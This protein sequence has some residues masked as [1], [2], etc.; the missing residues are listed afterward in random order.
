MEATGVYAAWTRAHFRVGD[1][2]RIAGTWYPVRRVNAK[3]LTVPPIIFGGQPRTNPDGSD[4]WTDRAPFDKVFGR[5]R[6]GSV[7]HT[8]PPAAG[9]LCTERIVIPTFNPEY[10]PQADGGPCPEPAIARVSIHHDGQAC[11]C[12]ERC[13]D[14]GPDPEPAQA[15]TEV[16]LWCTT[17][18]HAYQRHLDAAGSA[19]TYEVWR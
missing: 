8:P 5:R 1:E 2:A 14:R 11:G 6:N 19:I 17:H 10:V 3:S 13:L 12:H 16:L 4:V 18:N 9:T 15:W 7:L